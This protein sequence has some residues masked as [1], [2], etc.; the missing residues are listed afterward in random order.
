[1]SLESCGFDQ[2]SHT[3]P[4]ELAT[5]LESGVCAPSGQLYIAKSIRAERDVLTPHQSACSKNRSRQPLH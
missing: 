4:V 5:E 3:K 1:M 2:R